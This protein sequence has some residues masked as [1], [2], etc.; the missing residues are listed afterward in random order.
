MIRQQQE[1]S[2]GL[3][4]DE[5]LQLST[6]EQRNQLRAHP[7]FS[8]LPKIIVEK[9]IQGL[10]AT[11][12]KISSY[13]GKIVESKSY[14]DYSVRLNYVKAVCDIG[15]L[16]ETKFAPGAQDGKKFSEMT[17]DEREATKRKLE[18]RLGINSAS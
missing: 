15:D 1:N 16:C 10:D 4:E 17:D 18:E 12:M 6:E 8:G 2:P 14:I 13:Q 7:G 9:L 11:E 5:R 3:P